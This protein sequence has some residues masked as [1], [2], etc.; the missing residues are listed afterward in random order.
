MGK[1]MRTGNG[2]TPNLV[3]SYFSYQI[4][5]NTDVFQHPHT[6]TPPPSPPTPAPDTYEAQQLEAPQALPIPAPKDL[7]SASQPACC[8]DPGGVCPDCTPWAGDS[9]FVKDLE[10]GSFTAWPLPT[11][12]C[13]RLGQ[14]K[15]LKAFR[16]VAK[17]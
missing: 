4:S 17:H 6:T 8:T 3:M 14:G 16:T 1:N 7:P 15:V 2:I 11:H 13:Y 10:V 5:A 12:R 9:C